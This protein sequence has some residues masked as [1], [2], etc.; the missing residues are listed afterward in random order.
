MHV[1]GVA[2]QS[3]TYIQENEGLY[4]REV[5]RLRSAG[6][7]FLSVSSS[8]SLSLSPV[9]AVHAANNSNRTSESVVKGS[10]EWEVISASPHRSR[11][12]AQA[13]SLLDKAFATVGCRVV[14]L[15]KMDGPRPSNFFLCASK[16]PL[17]RLHLRLA[18]PKHFPEHALFVMTSLRP[19]DIM[20]IE[21]QLCKQR[22][23]EDSDEDGSQEGTGGE[24]SD[25]GDD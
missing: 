8:N 21:G 15:R 19:A 1:H 18:D 2:E 12:T 13:A 16:P 11:A 20:R 7:D 17:P 23:D 3:R 5:V 9:L 25:S 4:N 10:C 22:D 24:F 14:F 6:G